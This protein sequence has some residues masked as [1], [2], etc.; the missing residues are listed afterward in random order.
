MEN[1]LFVENSIADT[2]PAMVKSELAKMPEDKQAQFVEEYKRKK[3][4]LVW[5]IFFF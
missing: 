3:N 4:L 5:P 1:Q 2:L